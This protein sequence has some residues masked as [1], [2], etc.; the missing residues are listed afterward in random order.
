MIAE[1]PWCD[2]S[3]GMAGMSYQLVAVAGRLDG[4]RTAPTS[5]RRRHRRLPVAF[6]GG[7][8]SINTSE[9]GTM[10]HVRAADSPR[11]GGWPLTAIP[12]DEFWRSNNP[13][14]RPSTS[15][16]YVVQLDRSR[17]HT[18]ALE[19][20][21]DRLKKQ[22]FESTHK[23]VVTPLLGRERRTPIAFFD[24]YLK[25]PNG[26]HWPRVRIEG[27]RRYQ[28]SKARRAGGCWL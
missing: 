2:G 11:I 12:F 6:H 25:A 1:Q 14:W 23:E 5:L 21:N 28:R 16:A 26:R 8:P 13:S 7:I 15:L 24:R 22:H 17:I 18:A 27:G 10:Q 9:C 20:S 3:V 19:G 4:P